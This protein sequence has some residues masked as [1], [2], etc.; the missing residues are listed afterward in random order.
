MSCVYQSGGLDSPAIFLRPS[1]TRPLISFAYGTCKLGGAKQETMN[2][3]IPLA[4]VAAFVIACADGTLPPCAANDPSN[5]N[6]PAGLSAGDP[7]SPSSKAAD[8]GEGGAAHPPGHEHT[9][10]PL[11]AL[12]RSDGSP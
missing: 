10:H 5:P 9:H 1:T 8:D 12:S 11:P 4:A 6:G 3:S 2:I 7:T